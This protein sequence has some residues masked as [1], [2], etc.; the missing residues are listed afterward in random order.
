[1]SMSP[2]QNTTHLIPSSEG[3]TVDSC[4]CILPEMFPCLSN[5]IQNIYILFQKNND[6]ILQM[7]FCTLIYPQNAINNISCLLLSG[8]E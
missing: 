1:M 2:S 3:T 6:F 4:L 7:L 5:Y 8:F